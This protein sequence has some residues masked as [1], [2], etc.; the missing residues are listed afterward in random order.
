[1]SKRDYYEVL[2]L[3][4]NASEAE[5]KKA[6]RVLARQYHPDINKSPEAEAR[7]KEVNEAHEV[8]SDPQRK[9][10]YDQFGH[11]GPGFEG[12]GAGFGGGGFGGEGFG[13]G[14]IFEAFFG[15]GQRR[16]HTGPERGS[17]LRLDLEIPFT[18]AIFGGEREV[19]IQ[20]LENCATCEA[21]GAA[22][23]SKVTSCATCHGTGQVQQSQR[24]PFGS[25]TQVSTCPK[26]HGEGKQVEKPCPDCRG[27]GRKK[28]I[29]TIKVKIPAGVDTGARLR[30]NGEGDA[31]QRGGPSGDLYIVLHAMPDPDRVFERRGNDIFAHVAVDYPDAVLGAEVE[32]P[33]LEGTTKIQINA[34]TQPG[35][36]FR[37][38]GK[39]VP[40]LNDPRRRGDLHVEIQINVPTKLSSEEQKALRGYASVRKKKKEHEDEGF[41]GAF[42]SALSRDR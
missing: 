40:H 2:G 4:R 13:F 38:K 25:F 39:G 42:K 5:I 35:S 14:D 30:V 20:H 7:F 23:G 17:D 28:A 8:L 21:T 41:M 31:G 12:F 18:E 34:G 6:Y 32:V 37:L 26:C 24:T 10:Q 33:T 15:G 16:S 3:G 36:V 9:A 19:A 22:P 27:Q 11:A 29:K 1:M